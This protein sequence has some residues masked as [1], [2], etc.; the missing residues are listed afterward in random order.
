[1]AAL[2]VLVT[3]VHL[4]DLT[5]KYLA[6]AQFQCDAERPKGQLCLALELLQ[7][8]FLRELAVSVR[9]RTYGEEPC[10]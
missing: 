8:R 9:G 5:S 2:D 3:V 6:L 4:F 1:M 7:V 10:A